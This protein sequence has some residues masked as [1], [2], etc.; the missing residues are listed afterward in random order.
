MP[1]LSRISSI[2]LCLFVC[3]YLLP[4]VIEAQPVGDFVH[5]VK[6]FK[7]DYITDKPF[8]YSPDD[9]WQRGNVFRMQTGHSGLFRNCD[10][11][12]LKR[13]SP[14]IC[15]KVHHEP[16]FPGLRGARAFF[17]LD[18]CEV[19]QRIRDGAGCCAGNCGKPGC[20]RCSRKK[21]SDQCTTCGIKGCTGCGANQ[22]AVPADAC[23]QCQN[24]SCESRTCGTGQACKTGQAYG[25]ARSRNSAALLPGRVGG[26]CNCSDS[27][28]EQGCSSADCGSENCSRDHCKLCFGNQRRAPCNCGCVD[29]SF[30]E[31]SPAGLLSYQAPTSV[32]PLSNTVQ[33]T[34]A[35]PITVQP[36][37]AEPIAKQPCSCLACRLKLTREN[38]VRWNEAQKAKDEQPTRSAK[39][40]G[41][42]RLNRITADS[43]SR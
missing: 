4:D 19:K 39:A 29:T 12:E 28:C 36:N 15:W 7:Q 22:V 9:P 2:F 16:D 1:S 3:Q 21:A 6:K 23:D 32:Q 24:G 35:Q 42:F 20:K 38:L 41:G 37:I 8:Q 25:T 34:T 30:D 18:L 40:P 13:F 26:R 5:S 14:Y 31:N 17:S 11:E 10:N 27:Q 43:L 33:P